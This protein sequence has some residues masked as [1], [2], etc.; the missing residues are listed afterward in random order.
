MDE[1]MISLADQEARASGFEDRIEH[2]ITSAQ[3]LPFEDE[4]LIHAELRDSFK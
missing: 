1:E 2:R 3:N 4:F